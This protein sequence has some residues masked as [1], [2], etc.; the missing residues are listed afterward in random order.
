MQ[1]HWSLD[2]GYSPSPK[3]SIIGVCLFE[4]SDFCLTLSHFCNFR[5]HACVDQVDL[6]FLPITLSHF[7]VACRST[8]SIIKIMSSISSYM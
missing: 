5:L 2:V 7:R 1:G 3:I 4:T 6:G 8:K